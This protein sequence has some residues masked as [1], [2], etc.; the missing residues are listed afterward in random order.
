VSSHP[1]RLTTAN[2]VKSH[3]KKELGPVNLGDRDYV[4]ACLRLAN[5]K[6]TDRADIANTAFGEVCT[7]TKAGGAL[8]RKLGK[9][10]RSG[11]P[12]AIRLGGGR[13][14]KVG[15]GV[16]E[17]RERLRQ[18]LNEFL[19][20]R[21]AARRVLV[22][23]ARAAIAA[24]NEAKGVRTALRIADDGALE[25]LHTYFPGGGPGAEGLLLAF[26]L[27]P[28]HTFGPEL[29][30][31]ALDECRKFFLA[32][33]NPKGGPRRVFCEEA[34]QLRADALQATRRAAN[35]RKRDAANRE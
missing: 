8:F 28:R 19:S 4:L 18:A 21:G 9:T 23:R 6:D 26:L 22:A 29:R 30:V 3:R 13:P 31:C 32:T 14:D 11:Y 33:K 24:F 34:C 10:P 2:H 27:S 17:L 25:H 20:K 7:D 12:R 1:L 35:K 5:W 15:S 16:T